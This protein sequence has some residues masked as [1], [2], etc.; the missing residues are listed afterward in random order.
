MRSH[1]LLATAAA[2]TLVLTACG[3]RLDEAELQAANAGSR[4]P[5]AA[6]P[7]SS[8]MGEAP[9]ATGSAVD[10]PAAGTNATPGAAWAEDTAGPAPSLAQAAPP[11][12]R[13]K[14]APDS[15][16]TGSPTNTMVP[17]FMM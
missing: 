6:N 10:A 17:L 14:T 13:S 15:H 7:E 8:A 9:A 16:W 2:C 11:R 4:Q 5:A 3:S 12:K 1:R